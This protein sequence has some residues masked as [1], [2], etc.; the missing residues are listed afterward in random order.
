[1]GSASPSIRW[2]FLILKLTLAC[3]VFRVVPTP[4]PSRNVGVKD[5]TGIPGSPTL[6]ALGV[7]MDG[8]KH[9]S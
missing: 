4:Y 2:C 5:S 9:D 1:M 7:C 3:S 8:K 6:V